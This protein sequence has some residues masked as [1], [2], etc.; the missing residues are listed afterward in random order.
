M[1]KL[2]QIGQGDT[3]GVSLE[4]YVCKGLCDGKIM[5]Y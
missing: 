5:G 4:K 3:A 2:V 1:S